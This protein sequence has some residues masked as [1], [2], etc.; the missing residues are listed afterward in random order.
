VNAGLARGASPAVAVATAPVTNAVVATLVS[1][2]P[3]VGVGAVGL[4]VNT[5]LAKGASPVIEGI[6][7]ATAVIKTCAVP[8]RNSNDPVEDF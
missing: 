4:P 1:L 5:G 7:S 3:A 6:S 8:V 2:S